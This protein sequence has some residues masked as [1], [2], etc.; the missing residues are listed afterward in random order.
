MFYALAHLED[1]FL[2]EALHTFAA[3]DPC[4]ISLSEGNDI[5]WDGLFHFEDYGIYALGPVPGW[6]EDLAT[7][8]ENFPA[9]VC[10]YAASYSYA[11]P[12]SV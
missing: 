9:N 1:S 5:Y 3:T 8:C 6:T 10:A 11:E 7:I 4:T 2:G 12:V